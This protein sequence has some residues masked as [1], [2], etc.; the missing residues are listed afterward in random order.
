MGHGQG[1]AGHKEVVVSG[2]ERV[3]FKLSEKER[4][5]QTLGRGNATVAE[6][7]YNGGHAWRTKHVL[8]RKEPRVQAAFTRFH[9][10]EA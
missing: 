9:N 5:W 3:R 1:G 6:D 10:F 7:L 8:Q 4:C 2:E